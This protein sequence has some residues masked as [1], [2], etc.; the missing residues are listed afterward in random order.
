ME[1]EE[2]ADLS[3]VRVGGLK[4][5]GNF[6]DSYLPIE[7][8]MKNDENVKEDEDELFVPPSHGDVESA[9]RRP[10]SPA[11]DA[12]TPPLD[13][14]GDE[15]ADEI[16]G[17]MSSSTKR[18]RLSS[19]LSAATESPANP[20]SYASLA[21]SRRQRIRTY[22]SRGSS[23]GLPPSYIL[24]RIADG[25]RH[26]SHPDVLWWAAIGLAEAN[27]HGRLDSGGYEALSQAL[28]SD[29]GK[30][31]PMEEDSM[32]MQQSSEDLP[33]TLTGK[34]LCA[35]E[36]RLYMLRHW[37][38]YE[39][40]YHSS[41][42]STKWSV[43]T[44]GGE[45][46]LR[47]MVAGMGVP[48]EE[49]RQRYAFM[50]PVWRRRLGGLM[51]VAA[52][53]YGLN[54]LTHMGFFRVTGYRSLLSATDAALAITA[55]LESP[56]PSS[57]ED[58]LLL[59]SFHNAM[60][61]LGTSGFPGA[62]EREGSD[63]STLVNGNLAANATRSSNANGGGGGC[64][65]MSAGIRRAMSSQAAIVSTAVALVEKNAIVRLKEFRFAYLHSCGVVPPNHNTGGGGQIGDMAH[66]SQSGDDQRQH[67]PLDRES[68][69]F[70][71]PL[72]LHRLAH[73]L[74]DMHR[75]NGRWT[76]PSR[77]LPLVL[78]A[79]RPVAGTY[80]VA[81][82][83]FPERHGDVTRNRFG[84][85]FDLAAK[86]LNGKFL[87]EKGFDGSVAEVGSDIVQRFIEQLHYLMDTN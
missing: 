83:N 22:Y 42:V 14:D 81:G 57:G 47:E 55:L 50:R 36:H 2:E 6:Y 48:L 20:T 27:T 30:I 44:E 51:E 66:L 23:H 80:L 49:A 16:D 17:N 76:G 59:S 61:A 10:T 82:Y 85:N 65:G 60:D 87:L 70:S 8:D 56:A 62:V 37:S 33:N 53:E 26:S 71:H 24:H 45:R 58:G 74:M 5:W 75:E 12:E 19:E 67:Y 15:H 25:T 73:F 68:E 4:N 79:E 41:Y 40:L 31:Y 63:V 7:E 9:F 18:R 13:D 43:W 29:L 34:I 78:A 69:F 52:K 1:G 77:S 28:R 46:T 86:S 64:H 39:A 11:T 32:M 35:K 84:P 54:E 38:L 3:S 72:A 21:A